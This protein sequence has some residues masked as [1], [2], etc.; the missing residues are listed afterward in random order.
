MDAWL[1]DLVAG[2][3]CASG[4]DDPCSQVGGLGLDDIAAGPPE[5]QRVGH[6]RVQQAQ[7][8]R[9]RNAVA[10]AAATKRRRPPGPFDLEFL[11]H[12]DDATDD[13]TSGQFP[14]AMA[15]GFA[16][17]SFQLRAR[18]R[19]RKAARSWQVRA[20]ALMAS[21]VLTYQSLALP[22]VFPLQIFTFQVFEQRGKKCTF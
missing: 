11:D 8:A 5:A 19:A 1:D 20:Q 16:R 15:C 6:R 22:I 13:T 4:D 17:L 14:P 18:G 9:R 21:A 7:A 10:K 2:P 12:Q 3:S